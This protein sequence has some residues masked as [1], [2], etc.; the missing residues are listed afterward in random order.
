MT[1]TCIVSDNIEECKAIDLPQLMLGPRVAKEA[2]ACMHVLFLQLC[3][4][5]C[6]LLV[7]GENDSIPDEEMF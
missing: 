6:A 3:L 1:P 5:S 4:V 2:H 7:V